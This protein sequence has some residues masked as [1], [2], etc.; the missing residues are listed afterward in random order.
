[1]A[2]PVLAGLAAVGIWVGPR[3]G[4]PGVPK[5]AKV[6]AP[7]AVGR[8]VRVPTQVARAAADAAEDAMRN[9]DVR[10][11]LAQLDEAERADSKFAEGHFIRARIHAGNGDAAATIRALDEYLGRN[12]STEALAAQIKEAREFDSVA[13]S[14]EFQAWGR[15]VG[16]L[17]PASAG[18]APE[19]KATRV[20]VRGGDASARTG[21]VGRKAVEANR[22][23]PKAPAPAP[24]PPRPKAAP[25]SNSTGALGVD[26]D[27]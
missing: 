20:R 3:L 19:P 2:V 10:G 23:E 14:R 21:D 9:G 26:P 1:M 17:G 27:L 22:A 24:P 15:E 4:G 11:A 18:T 12:P 8:P 25:V 13:A 5:R 7:K 6:V 16:V